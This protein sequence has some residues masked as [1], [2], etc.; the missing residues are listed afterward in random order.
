M[1]ALTV[2]M[3]V[4]DAETFL[5]ACLESVQAL[6]PEIVIADTGSADRSI[7]IAEGF[8]ARVIRIPWNNDFAEARNR[9]LAE[10]HGEWILSLDADEQLDATAGASLPALLQNNNA[11]GYQVPIRNYVTNTRERI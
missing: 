5:A 7:A 3:I 8:G 10:A 4:R 11:S 1:T 6:S 9:A 2:S